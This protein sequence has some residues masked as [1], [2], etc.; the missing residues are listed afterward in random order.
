MILHV[1]RQSL[2]II[3]TLFQFGVCDIASN[4]NGSCEHHACLHG[5]L[6][7]CCANLVHGLIE[8]NVHDFIAEIIVC[9]FRKETRWVSFKG[10]DED[11]I[12]CD[13]A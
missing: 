5:I 1:L 7:Q 9:D 3:E 13:L 4:N 6:A 11:A 8:I 2:A 12:F 10:L